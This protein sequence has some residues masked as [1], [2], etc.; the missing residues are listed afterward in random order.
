MK[1]LLLIVPFII[2]LGCSTTPRT[3]TY[4]TIASLTELVRV[5]QDGYNYWAVRY[6]QDHPTDG[7][8]LIRLDGKVSNAINAYKSGAIAALLVLKTNDVAPETLSLLASNV[9]VTIKG[10]NGL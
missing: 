10:T 2:A 4:N 6:Q 3:T 5:A 9:F 8:K 1:K 7:G